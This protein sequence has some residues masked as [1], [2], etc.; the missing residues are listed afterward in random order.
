MLTEFCRLGCEIVV[1]SGAVVDH[2]PSILVSY[3]ET[4]CQP[5]F[6]IK[7]NKCGEI[8]FTYGIYKYYNAHF[9]GPGL[10]ELNTADDYI[11]Y[12][13]AIEYLA[14][15]LY[16]MT[17]N[18]LLLPDHSTKDK[19]LNM[20]KNNLREKMY[21]ECFDKKECL[22]KNICKNLLNID[23][24]V[25]IMNIIIKSSRWDVVGF[26]LCKKASAPLI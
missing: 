15:V 23:L 13:S 26:R 24:M 19:I 10:R 6:K 17:S 8:T 11:F 16:D 9:G 1:P 12:K 25:P 20:S 18:L 22:I 21:T 7:N 5:S 14:F 2:L 3:D 4:L